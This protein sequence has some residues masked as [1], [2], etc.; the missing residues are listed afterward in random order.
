[1]E[2]L[3]AK[4]NRVIGQASSLQKSTA[5]DTLVEYFLQFQNAQEQ[6]AT[7][8]AANIDIETKQLP[9]ILYKINT[10]K[11]TNQDKIIL[12]QQKKT[13]LD[14]YKNARERT[15]EA[16]KNAH[17]WLRISTESLERGITNY[18]RFVDDPSLRIQLESFKNLLTQ[19]RI[20]TISHLTF[21]KLNE[22]KINSF[23]YIHNRK[24]SRGESILNKSGKAI[25]NTNNR[26]TNI[27]A[28]K[29]RAYT[30]KAPNGS[31]KPVEHVSISDLR[32]LL[33]KVLPERQSKRI[34]P[35]NESEE[36]AIASLFPNSNGIT[37]AVATE[38]V[39]CNKKEGCSVMG[40]RRRTYKRRHSHKRRN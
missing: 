1:M 10:S 15:Q 2:K 27:A 29:T 30:L 40:G 28:R 14:K 22:L 20:H 18:L 19:Y 13:E 21:P 39:K 35:E 24:N 12:S 5:A 7:A 8:A 36:V 26:R 6:F 33:G 25:R 11:L 3:E 37:V 4:K 31:I 23:S 34:I 17:N 32:R 16:L 9:S 38:A